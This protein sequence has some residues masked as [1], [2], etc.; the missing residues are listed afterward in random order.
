[1]VM[2]ETRF[3]KICTFC[4]NKL[5]ICSK[6]YEERSG[7]LGESLRQKCSKRAR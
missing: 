7:R 1:M 4:Q 6:Y 5:H 3:Y 2:F